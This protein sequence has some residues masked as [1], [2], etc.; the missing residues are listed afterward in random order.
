MTCDA[1]AAVRLLILER[2]W[3]EAWE[4]D[5]SALQAAE[6]RATALRSAAARPG[7][8]HG[9]DAVVAALLDDLDVP[10]GLN[11]AQEARGAAAALLIDVLGLHQHEHVAR[12]CPRPDS[13]ASPPGGCFPR[14]IALDRLR[15]RPGR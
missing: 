11:I 3:W 9:R 10:S 5:E 13:D 4:F 1:F 14:G 7:G 2:R 12:R 6:V 8:H 15:A